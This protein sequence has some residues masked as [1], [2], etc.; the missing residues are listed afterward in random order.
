[1]T[2]PSA[3]KRA[4]LLYELALSLVETKG[5]CISVGLTRLKEFRSSG[6]T[7]H[8]MPSSAICMFGTDAKYL[9]TYSLRHRER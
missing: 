8:Y 3:E 5:T 2:T 6:F 4:L 9:K 1:V 7:I